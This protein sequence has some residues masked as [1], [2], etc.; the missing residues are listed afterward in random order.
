M[1]Y[2]ATGSSDRQIILWDVNSGNQ[3]RNFQTIPGAVRSLKF[4]RAGTHLY[5]GNDLGEIVIFDLVQSVPIDVVKSIQSRA[6]WSIDISWDDAIVAIGT[7]S[8]TIE[9]YSQSKMI[10]QAGS[11]L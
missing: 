6:I 10:S 4:N 9:L 1:H 3:A 2:L 5:V 11:Q 7:E 8:G